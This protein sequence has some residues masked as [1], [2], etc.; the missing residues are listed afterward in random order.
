MLTRQ[1]IGETGAPPPGL[2][3]CL[4]GPIQPTAIFV[5]EP[6]QQGDRED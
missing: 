4:C 3:R 2:L 5:V 1:S 6:G